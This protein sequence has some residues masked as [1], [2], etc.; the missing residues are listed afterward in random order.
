MVVLENFTNRVENVCLKFSAVEYV[1]TF[2]I[3]PKH[4]LIVET[5]LQSSLQQYLQ[6]GF[7]EFYQSTLL[8]YLQSQGFNDWVWR[9]INN[10]N[11]KI[12]AAETVKASSIVVFKL[13]LS[14]M[15]HRKS[16]CLKIAA[17]KSDK[18]S[19]IWKSKFS[20]IEF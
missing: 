3:E 4:N 10:L 5:F 8:Q 17:A 19:Q 11:N 16:E 9:K 14:L 12:S 18:I 6:S 1:K 20:I 2:S 7:G 13:W 15:K